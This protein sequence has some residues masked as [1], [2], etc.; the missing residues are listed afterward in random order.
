MKLC[1]SFLLSLFINGLLF[2]ANAR[3]LEAV[4]DL[5][6]NCLKKNILV[7][8]VGCANDSSPAVFRRD[9]VKVTKHENKKLVAAILAFPLPFGILGLHR[10]YF[11]TKPYIPFAYIGT[12]GGCLGILPLIDFIDII[13]TPKNSFINMENNPHIFMWAH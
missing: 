12:M 8:S 7:L 4:V 1:F 5:D 10:I 6:K 9:T 13:C 11:G 3:P 2:N